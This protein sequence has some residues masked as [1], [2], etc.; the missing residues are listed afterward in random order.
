[1]G[2]TQFL[3]VP[4]TMLGRNLASRW[5]SA[6]ASAKRIREVLGADFERSSELDEAKTQALI[7]A[8]PS[9]LTVVR[10]A[11]DHRELVALLESLP[12]NR[13]IAAPHVADL[14]DGT[15]SYNLFP[16]KDIAEMCIRDRP[17]VM[18]LS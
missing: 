14:F 11:G 8:L 4:M 12:R 17:C 18:V 5:A 6:E 2:L 13:V 7:D 1:M 10:S 16:D 9:G 15:V 3:I